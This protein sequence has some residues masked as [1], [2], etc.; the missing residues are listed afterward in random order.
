ML[1]AA[2]G[3]VLPLAVVVGMVLVLP[4]VEVAVLVLEASFPGDPLAVGFTPCAPAAFLSASGVVFLAS[5]VLSACEFEAAA[6]LVLATFRRLWTDFTPSTD[7]ATSFAW[8]TA[9]AVSTLPTSVTTPLLTWNFTL[10]SAGSEA[11][12]SCSCCVKALLP[13]LVFD[14]VSAASLL[15]DS[16]LA[17]SAPVVSCAG[18]LLLSSGL[19]WAAGSVC[20]AGSFGVDVSCA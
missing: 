2:L 18:A 12:L 11:N 6:A 10:A 4:P 13:A 9:S 14:G 20:C 16:L 7:I 3:A 17:D 8:A 19:V 15:L 1:P 5:A